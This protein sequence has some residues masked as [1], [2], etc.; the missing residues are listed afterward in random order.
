M[1]RKY[2]CNSTV[3]TM[4]LNNVVGACSIM[5]KIEISL[6]AHVRSRK[7]WTFQLTNQ[8]HTYVVIGLPSWWKLGYQHGFKFKKR[9]V[10]ACFRVKN[11]N[12]VCSSCYA[13]L[14]LLLRHSVEECHH[15][16]SPSL[17]YHK[18]AK[19]HSYG[20]SKCQ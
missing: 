20:G 4:I 2:L 17:L 8:L 14:T 1:N 3:L 18:K 13:V 10:K 9:R 16:C 7:W 12:R 6:E 5:T 15:F 11:K 19:Y